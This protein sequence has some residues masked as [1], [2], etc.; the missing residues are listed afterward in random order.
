MAAHSEI[1]HQ[2]N[3]EPYPRGTRSQCWRT[4]QP[5]HR[6]RSREAPTS[7]IIHN[8]W[9]HSP[10]HRA[11]LLDPNVDSIGIA[12]VTRD[13]PALRSRRLRHAQFRDALAQPA[14]AHG[15]GRYRAS[16]GMRV[17]ATTE[18][19][20]S[21]MHNVLWLCGFSPTLVHHAIH[22]RKLEPNSGS[23]Q[24]QTGVRQV[25]SGR[26]RSL[27]DFHG[28]APFTAYNIAVLL[29]P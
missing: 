28:T 23:A 7:V 10:G 15:C 9:M 1:S 3:G 18:R 29:Y 27:L 19:S 25:S 26:S 12:I 11:N 21:D 8:L 22:R 20:P 6:K 4:L 2:F 16:S 17:A 14:G 5:H 13:Q 24:K